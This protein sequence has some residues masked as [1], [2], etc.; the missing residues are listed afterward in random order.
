MRRERKAD[1]DKQYNDFLAKPFEAV[2][3]YEWAA[4]I[5]NARIGD[6]K[7]FVFNGNVIN[8]GSSPNLPED[9]CVEIPV[10]ADRMGF[11]ATVAGKLPDHLAILA[12]TTARIENLAIEAAMKKSKDL[13]YYAVY[14][15]P[16]SSAVC[17]LD[18]IKRMCDEL[19]EV[20]RD[21]LPE[22]K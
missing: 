4:D 10:V 5:F 22:Y 2:K 9:A 13:V 16:L 18:E 15:D 17:S 1:P 6:G 14:N 19:F 7:P 12:N 3:S 20:N 21:Y 11:K 8:H